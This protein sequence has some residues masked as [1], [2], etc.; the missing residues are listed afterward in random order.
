MNNINEVLAD[1]K[2]C[3]GCRACVNICPKSAIL[4][5]EDDE[6]FFYPTIDDEKCTNC[7]LCKKVCPSLNKSE[8]FKENTKNPDCYAV[9]ADDETRLV[10]SSGGAFTLIADEIFKMGGLVCG[11]AYVGQKVQHIIINNKEDL[12]KLRGSKYLQSDTNSVYSQ[13]K[14]L[15][16]AGKIVLFTGTPC[17]VAGL[18][19]FLGK[20]YENLYTVDLI[21][22]GVP[23]QKVFDKYL[24]ETLQEDDKFEHTSFRDKKAGWGVYATTTTTT[25]T[26]KRYYGSP[27]AE[28][29]YLQAFIKNMCLR[30]SCGACAYTTSQ[31]EADITI[32]DFW[33][34]ERFDKKLNDNK[35]TSVVL[36][37]SKKGKEIFNKFKNKTPVCT[38]VPLDYASYYNITLKTPLEQHSNRKAFF[39]MLKKGKSL[40]ETVKYCNENKYDVGIFNLWPFKNYGGVLNAY[41]L[42][43]V[44]EKLGYSSVLINWQY[45]EWRAEYSGSFIEK[46]A[47]KH[48]K[49]TKPYY[50]Y[51]E[52]REVNS[53][54]DT[55]IVGA[56]C[57]WSTLW[58]NDSL[59][60]LDF[61]SFDKKKISYAPSFANTD[62]KAN[63]D[64]TLQ[65]K[66]YLEKF[67]SLS[68]R[69]FSGQ[70]I[71]KNVFNKESKVVLDPTLLVDKE[72]YNLLAEEYKEDKNG[73]FEYMVN[74]SSETKER[75]AEWLKKYPKEEVSLYNQTDSEGRSVGKWLSSIKNSKVLVTNS[76]HACCFAIIFNIPFW[77][78][79]PNMTDFSRFETLLGIFDLSSRILKD[80]NNYNETDLFKVID[81]EKVNSILAKEKECSIK[82]LKEVLEAP[83][84]LSKINPADAVIKSLSDKILALQEGNDFVSIEGLHNVINYK[85][86]YRKYLK[87][88]ILKNFVFGAIK[89]CYKEKQKIY[90]KKIKSARRVQRG[91]AGV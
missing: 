22:H 70:K 17:Q 3:V 55:F 63:F 49:I 15:L 5:R 76:Y 10:S 18:N 56:D 65:N 6:G 16:Q 39:R 51:S 50:T 11:V 86:N 7:G 24:E 38:K 19:T 12:Y 90:H 30:P 80:S 41:A 66:Y 36:L 58:F 89:A 8:I 74:A 43:M 53:Y 32:G 52:L 20:K 84:D 67:D 85:K 57:V 28:D 37:N 75:V 77:V 29:I 25:I 31:R 45:P 4:M 68:V 87:Y 69:E 44:V 35:G 47:N 81:W 14:N 72:A 42:Q 1:K 91:I 71:L 9:I 78:V 64:L 2:D 62:Y 88:K 59:N 26:G 46:F 60:F 13:I 23:P 40:R 83:K 61:V 34:I 21:C 79:K 82:W 27:F 73:I 54:I 33:A 48:L